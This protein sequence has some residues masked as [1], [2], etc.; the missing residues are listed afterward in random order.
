[1]WAFR[2][3]LSGVRFLDADREGLGHLLKKWIMKGVYSVFRGR[4]RGVRQ[5]VIEDLPPIELFTEQLVCLGILILE[6]EQ[7]ML[8]R[9]TTF[10]GWA[11][12]NYYWKRC[13]C[14]LTL[15]QRMTKCDAAGNATV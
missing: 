2:R 4:K 12:S 13:E 3:Y 6:S 7:V 15:P 1:M 14:R 10:E 8:Q 9:N 5:R 11:S